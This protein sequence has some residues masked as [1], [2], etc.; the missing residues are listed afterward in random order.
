[1]LKHGA[2]LFFENVFADADEVIGRYP[3]EVAVEGG[4]VQLAEG[5]AVCDYRLSFGGV[6]GDDVGGIEKFTV[7]QLAEGALGGV[8]VENSFPEASLVKSQLYA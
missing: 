8:G 6:V 4:V 2:V 1:M 7:S 3:D 5:D